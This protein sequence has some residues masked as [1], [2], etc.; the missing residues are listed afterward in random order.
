MA[1]Y[2]LFGCVHESIQYTGRILGHLTDR[3]W[4]RVKF[5]EICEKIENIDKVVC[6]DG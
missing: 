5:L 4:K 1:V 2:F 3:D 6:Q